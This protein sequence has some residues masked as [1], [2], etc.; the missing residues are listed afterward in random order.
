MKLIMT[1]TETT[2]KMNPEVK[3]KWLAKLR[4]PETKQTKGCLK[5]TQGMCCLG[6]LCDIYIKET[7]EGEWVDLDGVNF[8]FEYD[9]ET[10]RL[11]LPYRVRNWSGLPQVDGFNTLS[12]EHSRINTITRGINGSV[13]V[14]ALNDG[15]Y[16]FAEIADIIEKEL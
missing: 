1:T 15:H 3:A 16:N 9:L 8:N 5:N 12:F 7:G 14:T 10:D 6:V 2:H 13:P 4:D 11:L